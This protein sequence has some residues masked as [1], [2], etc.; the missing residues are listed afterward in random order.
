MKE[1]KEVRYKV[2]S[3]LTYG[4]TVHLSFNGIRRYKFEPNGSVV[5]TDKE[6]VK[7]FENSKNFYVE[8]IA[9]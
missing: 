5:V 9:E 2:T 6:D 3:T 4:T 7:F 1:N 8:K